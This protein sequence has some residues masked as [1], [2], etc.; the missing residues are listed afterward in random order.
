MSDDKKQPVP[1]PQPEV[2]FPD[3]VP[4]PIPPG[5]MEF[6]LSPAEWLELAIM[7]DDIR[8]GRICSRCARELPTPTGAPT[9]CVRCPGSFP[10]LK[11]WTRVRFTE[12]VDRYPHFVIPKG[13]L[14][15]VDENDGKGWL[16]IGFESDVKIPGL[17][18]EAGIAEWQGQFQWTADDERDRVANLARTGR[19][20]GRPF[21]AIDD[22][23]GE[24]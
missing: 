6:I 3:P 11:P 7:A 5:G 4:T 24:R 1:T 8:S 12:A 15:V 20:F 9:P 16:L 22:K 2:S 19:D 23:G 21:V 14:G 13:T 18:D 10:D 17:T